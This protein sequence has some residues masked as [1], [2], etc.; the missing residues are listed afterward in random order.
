VVDV[1][2]RSEDER[3]AHRAGETERRRSRTF[4]TRQAR[5][6]RL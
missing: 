3:R 2:G 5:R 4:P 6:R 1:P